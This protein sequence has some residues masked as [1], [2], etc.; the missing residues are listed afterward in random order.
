MLKC[1]KFD[2]TYRCEDWSAF[3]V[4]FEIFA[5]ASMWTERDV[6]QEFVDSTW[7]VVASQRLKKMVSVWGPFVHW[8]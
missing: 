3:W 7:M 6:M 8:H 1:F 5:D 4:K 2:G